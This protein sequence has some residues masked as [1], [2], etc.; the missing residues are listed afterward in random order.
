MTYLLGS[1]YAPLRKEFWKV[2]S[3]NI[4]PH[5][6]SVM[7][8]FGA[9]DKRNLT[10]TILK[11]LKEEYPELIKTVII[12]RG[13][14]NIKEIE[15]IK[16]ERSN[17]EYYPDAKRMKHIMLESDIAISAGGQT[18]YELARVGVPTIGICFAEEQKRNLESWQKNGFIEYAGCHNDKNLLNSVIHSLERLM[19]YKERAKRNNIGRDCIDGKGVHRIVE[20]IISLQ[21]GSNVN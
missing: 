11:F 3:K 18:L 8:T 5:I 14:Q 20:K 21:G 19:P 6:K 9:G 17:L 10:S 16:D 13:Y 2:P 15:N 7:V 4:K 1:R 12:G